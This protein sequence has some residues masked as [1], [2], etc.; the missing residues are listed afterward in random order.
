M[1]IQS[2]IT[3]ISLAQQTQREPHLVPGN[4]SMAR[5]GR[6]QATRIR[7]AREGCL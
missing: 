7:P 3:G 2:E 5:C 4:L 6:R 1:G